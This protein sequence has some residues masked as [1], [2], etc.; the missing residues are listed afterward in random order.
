MT[1]LKEQAVRGGFAKVCAQAVTFTVRLGSLMVLARLLEPRDFGIVGMVTAVIGVLSLLKDFGLSAASVQRS[2]VSDEQMSTLFWINV[3]VGAILALLSLAAAPV[4]AAFYHEP[5]LLA[6]T[7]VMAAGFLF[8]AAGVQHSAVLQRQMRFT[9]LSA[10]D[11]LSLVISM[12]IGVVMA[13]R[14]YGYW[15]LVGIP[16]AAPLVSTVGFWL[17]ARWVPGRP[18]RQVGVSSMMRFGGLITLNGL[19]VYVAYNLEKVLLGRYWGA[20]AVGLY[21]RAYQLINIPTDNLNS[22]AG[23]VAFAALSRV[24]EDTQRLKSYF[25][26]GYALVL[27][28]TLPVTLFAA[29]FAKELIFVVLGPKW[30][31]TAMLFRLLAP[32]ILI[33]ALI[34]P[35]GWLLFSLGMLGRSLKIALVLTPL[36]VAAYFVGLPYG[37]KGVAIAY[38]SIMTLWAVPH[39]AWGIRG[40]VISMRDIA[41]AVSR[42]LVSGI[43]AGALALA[44]QL[45]GNQWWPPLPRLLAGAGVFLG[46]YLWMLMYVMGQKP[47][48]VGL[49][50]G[51]RGASAVRGNVLASA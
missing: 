11:I 31:D 16:V 5:R 3:L 30:N 49:V 41:L 9:A 18:R 15:A 14:G 12:A 37:P 36:V 35:I 19:I 34:N 46:V 22:A 24:Q 33:F 26:K 13:L 1:G 2:S 27:A 8:N 7:A 38:S 4:L 43:A 47:F 48:Y 42:P 29:L 39:I 44:V 17:T 51:L 40:T 32:T 23:G 25:L 21:G 50:Q 28:L 45:A 6:V 10:I 20:T